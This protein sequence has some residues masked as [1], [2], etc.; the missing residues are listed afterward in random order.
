MSG[1]WL[2]WMLRGNDP[3]AETAAAHGRFRT[4][5]AAGSSLPVLR[6]A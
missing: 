3:R 4:K 2:V 5:P 6:A 1:A